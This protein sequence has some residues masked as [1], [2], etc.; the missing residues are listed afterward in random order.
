MKIYH[1]AT[2]LSIAVIIFSVFEIRSKLG[3]NIMIT[4][5]GDRDQFPAKNGDIFMANFMFIF[6]NTSLCGEIGPSFS[7][8]KI[9]S[10]VDLAKKSQF[11]RKVKL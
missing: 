11:S 1:L 3:A 6:L 2:L 5:F 7:N 4:I 9:T 8:G 10:F